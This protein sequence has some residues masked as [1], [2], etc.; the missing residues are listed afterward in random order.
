MLRFGLVAEGPSDWITLEAFVRR[1]I[2]DAEFE[3]IQ[4][5]LTPTNR[6]PY[7]WKGVRAWCR[8][9]GPVLH[10]FMGGVTGRR[11]DILIIHSDCS[12]AHNESADR[13]CPPPN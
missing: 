6:S 1:L 13:P 8:E 12:M 4:P 7:G 10:Q 11:I 5:D 2:V 9:F 3:R